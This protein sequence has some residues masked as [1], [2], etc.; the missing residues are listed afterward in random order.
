M[1][2]AV[3]NEIGKAYGLQIRHL[4][5]PQTGY[6]SQVWP[7]LLKDG[8]TLTIILYKNEPRIV[9][10][11]KRANEVGDFIASQG[12]PARQTF[13]PRIL[14]LRSYGTTRYAALYYYLEG[15]T[16]PWEAYT[17]DHLKLLGWVL[18]AM[19]TR[20]RQQ[21]FH[22]TTVVSEYQKIIS[23][24]SVYFERREVIQAMES[25]LALRLSVDFDALEELL[26]SCDNLPGQQALHMDFVRGNVLYKPASSRAP[27]VLGNYELSGILDFEKT[28][29]GHPTFDVARTLAFLLVDCKYKPEAKIRKYF[30]E[31]GYVK[32][33]QQHFSA[34]SLFEQLVSLFLVYDF[35]KFLR[36]NPYESLIHNEHFE[37]T[38]LL[39]IK[40]RLLSPTGVKM[41]LTINT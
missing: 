22:L 18:G 5:E 30:L 39:L 40:R 7:V 24:M 36:H 8:R 1:K 35:Y 20:L 2:P 28:A 33:G 15:H 23:R 10:R 27:F 25:K 19:H 37:R 17:M 32:R 9:D 13:D 16:I 26:N 3:A 4:R 29:Y 38:K 14:R 31:S 21:H 6:R 11:M 41:K 12:L 34:D